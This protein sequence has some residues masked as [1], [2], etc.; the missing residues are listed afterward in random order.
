[1]RLDGRLDGAIC[2][3][4][5]ADSSKAPSALVSSEPHSE[6]DSS[7]QKGN[8]RVA[9]GG[10]V[11][12]GGCGRGLCVWMGGWTA[13]SAAPPMLTRHKDSSIPLRRAWPPCGPLRNDPAGAAASASSASSPAAHTTLLPRRVQVH[14]DRDH[15]A[16]VRRRRR[17]FFASTMQDAS[18]QTFF[19]RLFN[20]SISMQS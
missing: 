4:S 18:L 14:H 15:P 1:M 13:P 7:Y 16:V 12:A 9:G 17:P 2:C 6:S 8:K 11:G 5:D 20:P 3:T 19:C 10:A